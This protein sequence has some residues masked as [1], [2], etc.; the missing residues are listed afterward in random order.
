MGVYQHDALRIDASRTLDA[1]DAFFA[2]FDETQA[3]L[4]A[5]LRAFAPDAVVFDISSLAPPLAARLGVPS[6]AV[7]FAYRS[8]RNNNKFNNDNN[9]S[10]TTTIKRNAL[11]SHA[12]VCAQQL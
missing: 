11:L 9:N 10:S 4:E 1:L 5:E 6:I 8:K 2:R 3:R 12:D 7:R